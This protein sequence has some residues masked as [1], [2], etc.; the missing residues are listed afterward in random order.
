MNFSKAIKFYY[1]K[2]LIDDS[3]KTE[4]IKSIQYQMILAFQKNNDDFLSK[5]IIICL[6]QKADPK[7][8]DAVEKIR[9]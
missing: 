5:P 7:L 4:L 2:T 1:N 6:N 8:K 9:K 3:S